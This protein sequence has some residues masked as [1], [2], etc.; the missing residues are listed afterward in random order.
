[1]EGV[2][3]VFASAMF[4]RTRV[5]VGRSGHLALTAVAGVMWRRS[6][7]TR[8][9]VVWWLRWAM[10]AASTASVVSRP[11]ARVAFVVVGSRRIARSRV[12]A[13][14]E[15]MLA[16]RVRICVSVRC[17]VR[18]AVADDVCVARS[19]KSLML[20]GG[21]VLVRMLPGCSWCDL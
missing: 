3:V 16:W 9:C 21:N 20:G 14:K 11:C 4:V 5:S 13:E 2:G 19:M 12:N 17:K 10:S 7:S 1:M 15:W 6:V 18:F 8:V